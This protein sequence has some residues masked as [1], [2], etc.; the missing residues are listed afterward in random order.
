MNVTAIPDNALA[1]ETIL[2]LATGRVR[3]AIA[4]LR[5]S[6]PSSRFVV[7]TIAGGCPEPRKTSLRYLRS[8]DNGDILDQA[9]VVWFPGPASFSGED[10]AEFHIHGGQAVITAVMRAILAIPG[11][12]LAEPGEFSRRAFLAGRIDLSAAEGIADLVDAETEAQ[13]RQALRQM[14]GALA[15]AVERWRNGLIDGL[16]QVEAELDFSD[17]GDVPD[18]LADAVR[19]RVGAIHDEISTALADGRRGERLREGF[20]VVIAGAPNA[21][22]STLFNRL[23]QRDAAIVSPLAG[24]TRDVIETAVD[25]DGLPVILVDTAGLRDTE[26][27]IEQEGIR[28]ARSRVASADLVLALEAFDSPPQSLDGWAAPAIRL[29]T[30]SDLAAPWS[31][32]AGL[33]VASTT[34]EGIA[35][36]QGAIS[37][38]AREAL[39][40]GSALLTRERH[41]EAIVDVME[42][43]DRSRV[44]TAP[45]LLAEDLR[46]ALR[47]LGRITGRVGVED[48]LD[49]VFSSFCIGK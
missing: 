23:L 21:G 48:V 2:A 16:A 12:R 11:C 8:P 28:R 42:A 17:E 10:M 26:D 9:L 45:E 29:W 24:T 43:L 33:A 20:T 32:F 35:A 6:G 34:G 19:T 40:T 41:R 5:L 38:R 46:M 27:M 25:I 47:S 1:R 30:K 37:E 36:L 44:S 18:S 14:D 7:E 4:I 49:R 31:G 15:S 3:S 39:G 13:R 22:K